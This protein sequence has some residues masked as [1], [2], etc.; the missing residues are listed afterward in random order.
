MRLFELFNNPVQYT[1]EQH[2][3]FDYEA[4]FDIKDWQYNLGMEL[5]PVHEYITPKDLA[6]HFGEALEVF[7]YVVNN[8]TKD[9]WI[10]IAQF[11]DEEGNTHITGKGNQFL[12][13]GTVGHILKT[14]IDAREPKW[15]LMSAAELNRARLYDRMIRRYLSNT[16]FHYESPVGDTNFM[17][18]LR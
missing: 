11:Q 3:Q 7:E 5:Y 17:V 16:I 8:S 9:D 10:M 4:F 15:L 14:V 6:E 12:V 1:L 13:F 18:Q 2:N